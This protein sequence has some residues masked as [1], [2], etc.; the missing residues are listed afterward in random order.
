IPGM[1]IPFFGTIFTVVGNMEPTGMKFFDQSI[2][3]TM[4]AAYKMAADSKEKSLQPITIDRGKIS[5]VLV[6]VAPDISPDRV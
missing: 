4:D 2:F 1:Q 3:M 6:Q 5:A